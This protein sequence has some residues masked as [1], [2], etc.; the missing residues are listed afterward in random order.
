MP[1]SPAIASPPHPRGSTL[2]IFLAPQG[3]AVS[4]APAGIHPRQTAAA[5]RYQSLPR[6]RGDPPAVPIGTYDRHRSPPH[7]RGSTPSYRGAP[8]PAAVSPAPAG[9]HPPLNSGLRR[10][11]G[12][13]RTRGDPPATSC[14]LWCLAWSPPHPRGS[15]RHPGTSRHSIRVSP[16]PAGIHPHRTGR[17]RRRFRLPRTRGDPPQANRRK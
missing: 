7:P 1:V 13:P 9:I 2:P 6:T 17:Q 4:P 11:H 12:L 8:Q 5:E 16:A 14:A 15:T 3:M 10:R